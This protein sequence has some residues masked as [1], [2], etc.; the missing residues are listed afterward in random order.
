M[1]QRHLSAKV[2]GGLLQTPCGKTESGET[3][4]QAVI[5]ETKEKADIDMYPY[6]WGTDP[7]FNC[8][9]YTYKL[10]NWEKPKQT[11]PNKNGP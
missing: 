6:Y 4:I 11:E 7:K 1:S 5:R 3:S 2:M 8:D 10:G 9:I